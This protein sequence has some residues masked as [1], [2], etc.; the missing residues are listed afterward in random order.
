[1]ERRRELL[2]FTL[3]LQ[4]LESD[5][6]VTRTVLVLSLLFSKQFTKS[7][8]IFS[9]ETAHLTSVYCN[10]TKNETFKRI[11]SQ[12]N[13]NTPWKYLELFPCKYREEEI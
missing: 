3:A 10:G 8:Y 2:Q 6:S 5:F 12:V 4:Y 9:V 13:L 7:N 11:I 1:M